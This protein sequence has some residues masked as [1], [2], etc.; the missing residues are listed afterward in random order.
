[1]SS[2]NKW[3]TAVLAEARATHPKVT[4]SVSTRMKDLLSGGFSDR[5]LPKNELAT[6]AKDL[7]ARMLPPTESEAKQ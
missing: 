4:E 1:M 7:I 3:V 5:H 6:V 2:G